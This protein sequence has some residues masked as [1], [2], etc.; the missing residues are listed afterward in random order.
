MK[1]T[2][3]II[4]V[5]NIEN[6]V[7]MVNEDDNSPKCSDS[8]SDFSIVEPEHDHSIINFYNNNEIRNQTKSMSEFFS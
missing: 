8:K 5:Q 4:N 7:K 2:K 1:K 6:I 3:N